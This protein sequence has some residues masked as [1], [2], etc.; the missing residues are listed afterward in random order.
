MTSCIRCSAPPTSVV[1]HF[2]RPTEAKLKVVC[3]AGGDLRERLQL[4]QGAAARLSRHCHGGGTGNALPT[5]LKRPQIWWTHPSHLSHITH[6]SSICAPATAT[7][8]PVTMN[9]GLGP[10]TAVAGAGCAH[11]GRIRP[12]ALQTATWATLD[13]GSVQAALEVVVQVPCRMSGQ[14][15][16]P[17]PPRRSSSWQGRAS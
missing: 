17:A 10:G 8:S 5:L 15:S 13:V 6:P 9:A 12:A 14:A 16:R 7:L 1:T 11:S 2:Q 3:N 4:V